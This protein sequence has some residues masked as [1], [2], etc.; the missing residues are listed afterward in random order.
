[1]ILRL[2]CLSISTGQMSLGVKHGLGQ[3]NTVV[4][5]TEVWY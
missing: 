1:M 2:I 3:D 4:L 5:G